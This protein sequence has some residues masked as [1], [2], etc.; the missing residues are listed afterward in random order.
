M[1]VKKEQ[2]YPALLSDRLTP[3][4]D[5]FA[6]LFMPERRFK[7]ALIHQAGISPGQRVLDLGAGTGTLAG[8]IKKA[9]PR[10]SVWGIDSDPKILALARAK[11]NRMGVAAAFAC[12]SLL[13]LP[14]SRESFEQAV[15]T[16]VMSLLD[17]G[18]KTLAIREAYRVLTAG[19]KLHIADFG[20]PHTGWGRRVAPR[21]RHFEPIASNLDGLLPVMFQEAGFDQ[22]Q[23]GPRFATFFG[24]IMILSGRKS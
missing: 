14:F 7:E 10:A 13:A 6:R 15:S 11:S 8:M 1:E 9:Q 5:L 20:P 17:P 23:E 12:G 22:I 3:V 24:T 19:G 4:Y 2:H 18:S 16:L 21:L